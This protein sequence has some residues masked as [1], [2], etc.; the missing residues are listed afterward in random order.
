MN[1]SYSDVFYLDVAGAIII[2]GITCLGVGVTA[3]D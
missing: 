1:G 3:F 2:A